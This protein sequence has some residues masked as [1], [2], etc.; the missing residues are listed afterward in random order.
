VIIGVIVE[1][2]PQADS[3]L[4]EVRKWRL[5]LDVL[6]HKKHVLTYMWGLGRPADSPWHITTVSPDLWG[7]SL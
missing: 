6:Q 4:L 5:V 1:V 3:E 2:V 7:C